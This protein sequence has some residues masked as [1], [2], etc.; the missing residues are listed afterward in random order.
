MKN[1]FKKK[2]KISKNKV[3]EIQT[4]NT[5]GNCLVSYKNLYL[6]FGQE[7]LDFGHSSKW[8]S[9]KIVEIFLDIGFNVDVIDWEDNSFMPIKNYDVVFDIHQNLSRIVPSLSDDSIKIL[10]STGS[11]P[12]YAA[13]QE[14]DRVNQ[15][16]KRKKKNYRPKR[17]CETIY[18]DRS[19]EV[20]N[21]ISLLGNSHTKS[22]FPKNLHEKITLLP[23]TSSKTLVKDMNTKD[24][25]EFLWFY[26]YGAVH[27]GLDILLDIFSRDQNYKLNI[28]GEVEI[29]KDFMDIYANE[30]LNHP[31]IEYHGYL[32]PLSKDFQRVINRCIAFIAPSC[33][34]STSTAALTCIMAGLYPIYGIDNGLTLPPNTGFLLDSCSHKQIKKGIRIVSEYPIMELNREIKKIKDFI[35]R[36]HSRESFSS[37]MKEFILKSING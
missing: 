16:I 19:A 9:K 34:E 33:S 31:N 21:A 3:V 23:V 32:D 28:V 7:A 14:I 17:I 5:I 30:L 20:A 22:T 15:L 18:F 37:K 10:H 8:E 12:K 2:N 24:S 1:I 29:E 26:G 6:D 36:N 13:N 35:T 4:E 27:K 25:K 11:H